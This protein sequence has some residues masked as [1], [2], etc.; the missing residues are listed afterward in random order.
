MVAGILQDQFPN[1]FVCTAEK[2]TY[3]NEIIGYNNSESL[4]N[5]M[6]Y[7]TDILLYEQSSDVWMPRVVIETKGSK[8][9]NS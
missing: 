6:A 8:Y 7:E 2:L 5:R 1:I 3:A 4:I 9:Y